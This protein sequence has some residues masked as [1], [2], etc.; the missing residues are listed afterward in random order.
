MDWAAHPKSQQGAQHR[1]WK[2]SHNKAPERTGRN[3]HYWGQITWW[4]IKFEGKEVNVF[5]IL[6]C[7]LLHRVSIVSINVFFCVPLYFPNLL[8]VYS[9]RKLCRECGIDSQGSKIE[10][11]LRLREEMKTRSKYDKI[12]QKVWGA[13][14]KWKRSQHCSSLMTWRTSSNLAWLP[15]TLVSSGGWAVVM[16][17]CGQV[18]SLKCN[19]R[20]ESPRDFTDLLLSWKHMPNICIYDFARGLAV[21][22]NLREPEM[23]PF[24]PHEGRLLDPSNENIQW[25]SDGGMVSLPWLNSRKTVPDP[26]AHPLT[27]SAEHYCLYDTFHER[28]TKDPKDVLRRIKMVPELTGRINSQVAEQL[29]ST[30]KKSNYYM[31]MLSPSAHVFLMRNV[32][33]IYNQRKNI[34]IKEEL[35]KLVSPDIPFGLN[36]PFGLLFWVVFWYLPCT[37]TSQWN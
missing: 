11:I 7:C 35:R 36:E 12:F 17:P 9:I 22:A 10:L 21:H 29:F 31:N 20:A 27:G 5:R 6:C 24:S 25:A 8:Q 3:W 23:L 26:G 16:C 32:I 4:S 14:G 18:V 13:S 34:I 1:I 2:G 19:L 28:N 15:W 30:M 33:H 37:P